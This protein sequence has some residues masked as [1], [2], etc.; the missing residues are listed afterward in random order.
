MG[1]NFC[2]VRYFVTN[3]CVVCFVVRCKCS[4]LLSAL[5]VVYN[6]L[7]FAQ[8]YVLVTLLMLVNCMQFLVISTFFGYPLLLRLLL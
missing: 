6:C 3:L 5:R 4:V 8:I 1:L 7:K 2:H